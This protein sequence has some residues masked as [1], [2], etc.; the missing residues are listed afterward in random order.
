MPQDG[1]P[2]KGFIRCLRERETVADVLGNKLGGGL[3]FPA[4]P[5]KK[6]S[7]EFPRYDKAEV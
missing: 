2:F 6:A 4:S 3:E 1:M 7:P 5:S